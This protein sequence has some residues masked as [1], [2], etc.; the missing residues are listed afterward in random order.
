MPTVF[1]PVAHHHADLPPVGDQRA[2]D[3]AAEVT[4]GADDQDRGGE[5]SGER[6]DGR[7][8]GERSDGEESGASE[9]TGDGSVT[10]R[11]PPYLAH[12]LRGL[13]GKA[14]RGS[15]LSCTTSPQ[16]TR[17]AAG[18]TRLPGGTISRRRRRSG[19]RCWCR[20]AGGATAIAASGS[21]PESRSACP[22]S[23]T[24]ATTT[25]TA[26]CSCRGNCSMSSR[27]TAAPLRGPVQVPAECSM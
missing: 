17:T 20:H 11:R 27:S 23:S 22:A 4:V 5:E 16:R 3:V 8:R 26:S 10:Q 7:V 18:C 15:R 12:P 21:S 9:A 6:S 19:S 2:R 24:L 13:V 14:A 25:G 1:A